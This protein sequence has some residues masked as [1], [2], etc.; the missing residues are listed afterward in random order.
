MPAKKKAKTEEGEGEEEKGGSDSGAPE[1][2]GSTPVAGVALALT[3]GGPEAPKLALE[4]LEVFQY[5]PD[6]QFAGYAIGQVVRVD[7]E[8]KYLTQDTIGIKERRIWGDDPYADCSD[9]VA[10]A[11]HTGAYT[12]TADTPKI[13]AL[14]LTVR[15]VPRNRIHLAALRSGLKSRSLTE[16]EH[17]GNSLRL[18]G[19]AVCKTAEDRAKLTHVILRPAQLDRFSIKS[20]NAF[21][22]ARVIFSLSNEP[23]FKFSLSMVADRSPDSKNWTSVRLMSQALYLET[24]DG[25][26]LELS[27][28]EHVAGEKVTYRI[29]EVASP[30]TTSKAAILDKRVPFPD[31]AEVEGNLIWDEIEWGAT[32]FRVRGV[33]RK[34]VCCFWLPVTA[35][36]SAMTA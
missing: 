6:K 9:M 12:P 17:T 35:G 34:L 33:T 19:C 25:K 1:K 15:V 18:E 2:D 23:A 21:A 31:A 16:V 36:P 14:V 8:A 22:E 3:A 7:V 10:I 30:R 4:G 24:D 29:A 11:A 26:R 28:Q 20:H 5:E 32:A 27:V 13:A